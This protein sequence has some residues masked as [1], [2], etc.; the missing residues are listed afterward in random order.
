MKTF[1]EKHL[2][3][4]SEDWAEKGFRF[5]MNKQYHLA[6]NC[7]A[8]ADMQDF[9]KKIKSL[10]KQELE[11]RLFELEKS[12]ISKRSTMTGLPRSVA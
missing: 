9:C 1:K 3:K 11:E 2:G 4:S 8:R 6:L 7:Y 5:Y 10:M 12:I